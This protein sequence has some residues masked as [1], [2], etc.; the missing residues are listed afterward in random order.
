M[1]RQLKNMNDM[2]AGLKDYL[3]ILVDDDVMGLTNNCFTVPH[4]NWCKY[5]E[6]SVN[7][8]DLKNSTP[9]CSNTIL[10]DRF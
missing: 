5:R 9:R 7:T 6:K 2:L 3:N 1:A 8:L 10:R 4:E